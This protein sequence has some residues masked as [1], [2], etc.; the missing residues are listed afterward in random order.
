MLKA[1]GRLDN[2]RRAP[3][4]QGQMKQ[5]VLPGGFKQYM[6]AGEDSWWPFPTALKVNWDGDLMGGNVVTAEKK[7]S[8]GFAKTGGGEEKIAS[9]FTNGTTKMAN[10]DGNANANG[11]KV[12]VTEGLE[13]GNGH[14]KLGT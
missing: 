14:V 8:N 4:P 10:G 5:V 11:K 13:N 9:A 3:G 6:T 1:V 7:E 12:V 2:L